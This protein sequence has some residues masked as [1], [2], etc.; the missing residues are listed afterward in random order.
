MKQLDRSD[1]DSL[2]GLARRSIEAAVGHGVRFEPEQ[3]DWTPAVREPAATFVTL[4]EHGELRGCIGLMRF[5]LPMWRN[6]RDAATAAALD[7]PRFP[8]VAASDV[9]DLL[10]E[11]SVLEPP[12]P[13]PD[14]AD[15]QAGRQGIVVERGTRRA[16]LL[17]QVAPEMGWGAERMLDAVCLKAGLAGDAWRDPATKLFVFESYCF[18]EGE[19]EGEGEGDSG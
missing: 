9:P 7:D 6:V 8:P 14:A 17:P 1:R 5:D 4:H 18:S 19:G 12:V 11:I 16:L 15:F 2:L 3:A 13:L 10:I